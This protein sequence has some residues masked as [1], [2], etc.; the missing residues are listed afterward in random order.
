MLLLLE[1]IL[2]TFCVLI[3]KGFYLVVDW[4]VVHGWDY[5]W[6]I[7]V[8]LGRENIIHSF[9]RI[10]LVVIG[11]LLDELS[12]R[13]VASHGLIKGAHEMLIELL[14]CVLV[15][16]VILL[17]EGSLWPHL[18]ESIS[19]SVG[20]CNSFSFV[21]SSW[22]WSKC[23]N[24]LNY[25]L[26]RIYLINHREKSSQLCFVPRKN[27]QLIDQL[28]SL[29]CSEKCKLVDFATVAFLRKFESILL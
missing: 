9:C 16:L 20:R 10:R 2:G 11:W 14:L 24:L 12:E 13:C 6:A 17:K 19:R 8:E 1:S 22:S 7:W 28:L 27:F 21:T 18:V 4:S 23:F 3:D 25:C 29:S 26:A 5:I 15:K